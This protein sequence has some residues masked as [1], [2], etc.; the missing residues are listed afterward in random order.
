MHA[1]PQNAGV[2]VDQRLAPAGLARLLGGYGERRAMM[3]GIA[4]SHWHAQAVV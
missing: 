3:P 2:V 1:R 4:E